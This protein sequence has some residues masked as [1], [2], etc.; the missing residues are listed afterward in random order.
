MVRSD[1]RAFLLLH[2]SKSLSLLLDVM[3]HHFLGRLLVDET[4]MRRCGRA[5]TLILL[6]R[7]TGENMAGF[8][9]LGP[10]TEGIQ[11]AD[12]IHADKEIVLFHIKQDVE[13]V[14]VGVLGVETGGISTEP[15]ECLS[16]I[17]VLTSRKRRWSR[18]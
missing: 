12:V 3:F 16:A 13:D 15:R 9:C 17:D 10:S 14:R 8:G 2:A 6:G 11:V 7:W 1:S 18:R 5:T 4:R